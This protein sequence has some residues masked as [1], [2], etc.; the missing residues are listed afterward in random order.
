MTCPSTSISTATNVFLVGFLC[1]SRRTTSSP[2]SSRLS[3]PNRH[4]VNAS[5]IADFPAPLEPP[6]SG[7]MQ[8]QAFFS[9][10]LQYVA[11]AILQNC[12]L[13]KE[14]RA[15]RVY[16]ELAGACC[17]CDS[18][19]LHAKF[20]KEAFPVIFPFSNAFENAAEICLLTETSYLR[21]REKLS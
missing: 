10:V 1:A 13:K 4:Q 18:K 17:A 19:E 14:S 11:Q 6:A 20:G 5:K 2:R 15:E 3:L 8:C 21:R 12:L 7:F 16:E 9:T